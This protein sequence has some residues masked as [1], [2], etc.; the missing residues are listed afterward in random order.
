MPADRIASARFFRSSTPGERAVRQA[1]Y[2]LEVRDA[3]AA[4]YSSGK[5]ASNRSTLVAAAVG[6]RGQHGRLSAARECRA[7]VAAHAGATTFGPVA[8]ALR[9]RLAACHPA[10]L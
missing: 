1:A 5:V 6:R 9:V 3:S 7:V 2:E 10:R 8:F 4:V